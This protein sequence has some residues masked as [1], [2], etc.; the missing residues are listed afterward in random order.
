MDFTPSAHL[1]AEIRGQLARQGKTQRDLAALLSL[2]QATVSAR[3][4][5]KTEFTVSELRAVAAWLDVPVSR[6]LGEVA[7]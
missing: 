2:S 5:G 1:L 4:T 7:A 3:M 6:L